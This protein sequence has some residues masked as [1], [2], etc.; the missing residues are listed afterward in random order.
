VDR[1]SAHATDSSPPTGSYEPKC[2][3]QN[4][5]PAPAA[6]PRSP[7]PDWFALENEP[8]ATLLKAGHFRATWRVVTPAGEFIAKVYD[9][10]QRRTVG[11]LKR[12]FGGDPVVRESKALRRASALGIPVSRVHAVLHDHSGGQSAIILDAVPNAITLIDAWSR[13]P[14]PA[15]RA[16]ADAVAR[17]VATAHERGLL[18]PD[19]HPENILMCPVGNSFEATLIDLLGAEFTSKPANELSAAQGIAQIDQSFQ[20][21]ASR[22]QR[23]RFLKAYL[24]LRT[25]QPTSLR[26]RLDRIHDA[27]RAQGESLAMKRDRRLRAANK[28]FAS[29][30][31]PEG[32]KAVVALML[33]RRHVFPEPEVP[34]RTIEQWS[35]MLESTLGP[36]RQVCPDYRLEGHKSSGLRQSLRWTLLSSPSKASFVLCH[37]RRHRD[38]PADLVLGYAEHRTALGLV[39]ETITFLPNRPSE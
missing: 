9:W 23:L 12:I 26:D 19:L 33:E 17:T 32:W 14:A 29:M 18:H 16:I 3:E 4:H 39:D 13:V 11:S 20:R 30:T 21:L 5:S 6:A 10:R 2:Q 27:K 7:T 35:N 36:S 37:V 31:L 15:R 34:D 24:N 25:P 28:Y 22:T 1:Q 8:G 38:E